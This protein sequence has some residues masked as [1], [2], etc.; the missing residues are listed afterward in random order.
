MQINSAKDLDVY[1]QAYA[2]AMEIF[3][4][5]KSWPAEEKYS[6]TDQIRRSSRSVCA[7]LKEAWSKRRYSAHFVNKLTDCDGENSETGTWLDFAYSCGYLS[8]EDFE[9][10]S[11]LCRQIGGMLGAMLKNPSPF[12]IKSDL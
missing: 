1:N 4:K 8:S 6:L 5:S 12:I 3:Q 10:L 7:N 11:Q 2:L 9:R